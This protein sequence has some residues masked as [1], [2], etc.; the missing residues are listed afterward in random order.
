MVD[1]FRQYGDRYGSDWLTTVAQAYLESGLEQGSIDWTEALVDETATIGA[2]RRPPLSFSW[3]PRPL[4]QRLHVYEF[5][6]SILP[7]LRELENELEHNPT[8]RPLLPARVPAE[9]LIPLR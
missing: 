3:A 8:T 1:L 6:L 5:V 2:P 9:V 7:S 4:T